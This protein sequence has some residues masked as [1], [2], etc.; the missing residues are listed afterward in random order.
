MGPRKQQDDLLRTKENYLSQRDKGQG[1]VD[2]EVKEKGEEEKTDKGE[3]EK[4]FPWMKKYWRDEAMV[5]QD[6]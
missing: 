3:Q 4:I 2:K 6:K 1:I 5:T